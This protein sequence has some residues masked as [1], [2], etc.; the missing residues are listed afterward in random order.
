M[1]EAAIGGKAISTLYNGTKRYD[2]VVRFLPEYRNSIDAIKNMQVP[3]SNGALIPMS[4]LANIHFVE[5]QTNIYR[6]GSKRMVT[7]RTNIRGRDQDGFVKELQ[8]KIDG[9]IHVPK[10]YEIIYGGQYAYL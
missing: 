5:G 4:Q 9:K 6:Y 3:A 8:K 1:I 7:V 10:G 2:I